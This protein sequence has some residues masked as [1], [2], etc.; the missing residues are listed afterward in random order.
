MESV[1]LLK[2]YEESMARLELA[3]Q[4]LKDISFGEDWYS[5]RIA[6]VTLAKLEKK[7]VKNEDL[8]TNQ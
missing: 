2:E 6:K 1:N 8:G 3:I 4:A 7:E 5:T